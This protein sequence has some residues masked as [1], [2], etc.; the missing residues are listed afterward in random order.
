MFIEK[1]RITFAKHIS[2]QILPGQEF[3]FVY[4]IREKKYYKFEDTELIV[5]KAIAS[6]KGITVDN[7]ISSVSEYYSIDEDKVTTDIKSFIES[8]Y[9]IGVIEYNGSDRYQEILRN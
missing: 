5:W 4:N 6:D 2:W 7:I 3:G 1:G 8:L 9:E